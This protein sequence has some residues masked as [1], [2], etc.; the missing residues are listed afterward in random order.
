ML[1]FKTQAVMSNSLKTRLNIHRVLSEDSPVRAGQL[2]YSVPD[3]VN[4]PESGG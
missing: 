4:Y 1:Y 2:S 3:V